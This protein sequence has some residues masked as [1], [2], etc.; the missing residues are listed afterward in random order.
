[1]RHLGYALVVVVCSLSVALAAPRKGKGGKAGKADAAAKQPKEKAIDPKVAAEL[2]KLELEY[3]QLVGKQAWFAAIKQGNKV[4]DL[5]VKAHGKTSLKAE[6]WLQT[7]A[8]AH[9]MA[10]DHVGA[11]KLY[12]EHIAAAEKRYGKESREVLYALSASYQTLQQQ[13][14]FDE[15]DKL[16]ERMLAISKKLDGA[17]SA[18]FAG[19]LS[20]YAAMMQLRNAYTSALKLYEQAMQIYEAAAPSKD[21]ESLIQPLQ[22]LA[23]MYWDMNQQAKAITL[24]DRAI[25]IAETNPKIEASTRITTL[26]VI[27]M[28]YKYGGRKDL[29]GPL[30]KKATDLSE[31]AIAALEKKDPDDWK[32][33]NYIGMLPFLY[34]YSGDLPKAEKAF[35]RASAFMMK[36]N[37]TGY[38]PYA[39]SIAELRKLQGK[40]KEALAILEAQQAVLMKTSPASAPAM[41]AQMIDVVRDL[42]DYPRAEKLAIEYR[43]YMG[44]ILGKKH[45]A[46]G[47]TSLQLHNVYAR[48]GKLQQAEK[49]LDEYLDYAE[50]D[51]AGVLRGG[52]D[53]D[54]S[55]YFS[56]NGYVLDT[57][58]NFNLIYA[59]KSAGAARLALTTLLRRKGRV[60]DAAAAALATL[61]S[62][63]S[64]EDQQLLDE[65]SSARNQLAKLT[66]A[67]PQG[68]GMNEADFTKAVAALEEKIQS[69]EEK[70]AKK[71]A[72][73]RVVTMPIELA[74]IQKLIPK[75]ARL[76]EVVNYQPYDPKATYAQLLNM[77]AYK[78]R[79][80]VAYIAATTGDPIYVDLGEA[81]PIEAA[82]EKF[83][84]AL[85]DPDNDAVVDLG[86]ALH[87]LT[88]AKIAAKLGGSTNVLIA[89]DGALNV[90]PFSAL[91]DSK[92]EF[93]VKKYTFTYLTS[94]RDLLRL[95]IKSKGKGG[96]V[97]FADPKFDSTG[98]A[99]A[100]PSDNK[101]RGRRSADLTAF[102]WPQLPGTAAEADA[103]TK[104]FKGLKVYRGEDATEGNLKKV[105]AP[106]VLHLATHGF[107]LPDE[108]PAEGEDANRGGLQAVAPPGMGLAV[109]TSSAKENPLLRSGLAL[110][111]ANKLVSGDDDGLLTALE[112]SGLN[113]N[114]TK[115][116]VLSA[117]ET[118][119]GKVTNGDGV[120]GL[121]R[122]LV[123]AGAESLVMSMWQVDDFATKELMSGFYK[124]LAAG[125]P[126]S[127]A[128]REVQLEL[129]AKPKYAHPF[130]WAAFVPAGATTP[131]KD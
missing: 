110:A 131:L 54:H 51:L 88:F 29:S 109:D 73:Y 61:R 103:V 15:L 56:K 62:K 98:K 9:T 21:D 84:K 10:G 11:E 3:Y 74:T 42:G 59:Q 19:Q 16:F 105:Q 23:R 55:L 91:V 39:G 76:V 83:R 71:S 79:R 93:L 95:S 22:A 65:L 47:F 40:Y 92:K 60:L 97:M 120:Y 18:A 128:L 57:A 80:Y 94:G 86:K 129:A 30:L 106:E 12:R 27:S 43:D 124:K 113:L 69:Y 118:G 8:S 101:T 5:A 48:W 41:G 72:A 25:K 46:Y 33:A 114:G 78:P 14:R 44:R 85:A 125:K 68:Q 6:S 100:A 20:S 126:R 67:G 63:L 17:T 108:E 58:I 36:K 87:D 122:S 81:A 115:L 1:M 96:G 121:R 37:P 127:A 90:V 99:P 38:D 102:R 107:F 119:V 4:Y 53:S 35:M 49:S 123:I 31:E 45:T 64:K 117:C 24:Y 26:W 50:R 116:V 28:A 111:G 75:D 2:Q 13:Q 66:V 82:I 7:L 34:Q 89:P 77:Q 104:M 112:A 130:F 52:T 70:I 32:L